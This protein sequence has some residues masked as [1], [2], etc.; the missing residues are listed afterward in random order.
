MRT[1]WWRV[2]AVGCVAALLG[3]A[4]CGSDDGGLGAGDTQPE[5]T[6]VETFDPGGDE[7]GDGQS[8]F[9][10]DFMSDVEE[11]TSK[12]P[13]ADAYTG[14]V[15]ISD[16]TNALFVEVPVE[17]DDVFAEPNDQD[18]PQVDASTDLDG[19]FDGWETSGLSYRS[20]GGA[21][22]GYTSSDEAYDDRIRDTDAARACR[23]EQRDTFTEAALDYT[24]GLYAGC[25]G[26]E[27]RAGEVFIFVR[28]DLPILHITYVL[29]SEADAEA[30][31]RVLA[32]FG[33]DSS[34]L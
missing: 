28:S 2:G 5:T 24:V 18:Q 16:D 1:T 7:D 12:L 14:F 25:G 23:F 4:G 9:A 29:A 34:V 13:S 8:T 32:S 33:Y 6:E 15:E 19:Y 26:T 10:D 17:F 22:L 11:S 27:S 20:L 31:E 3:A 21:S 30:F